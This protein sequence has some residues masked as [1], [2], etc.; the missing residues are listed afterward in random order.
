[1]M[2]LLIW[3]LILIIIFCGVYAL[4]LRRWILVGIWV[5]AFITLLVI[6]QQYQQI[7]TVASFE[8]LDSSL[9]IMYQN[10]QTRQLAYHEIQ[11]IRRYCVGRGHL[12]CGLNLYTV[13]DRIQLP[14]S[15]NEQ[16]LM[17]LKADLQQKIK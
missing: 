7:I 15:K 14:L 8:I 17:Q 6:K 16:A 1:M 3:G 4:S 2:M 12:H 13:N 10:Q 11:D 5:F 9:L